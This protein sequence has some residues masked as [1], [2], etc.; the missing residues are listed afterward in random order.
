MRIGLVLPMFSGDPAK[1][2]GA[3]R[4]AEALGY[5]GVYAFDHFFP[6]GGSPDRPS[7][8]AFT[9][10]AAVAAV[11]ERVVIGTLVTRAS[12][13]PIGLLAKTA[14]W[15]D[16]ASDGRFVL[17]IG[18]GD[19]IDRPEHRAYGIPMLDKADRRI[20]LEE[21]LVALRTL[22]LGGAYPGGRWVPAIRGPLRPPASRPGGPPVWVGAQADEVVRLAG[23]LADGWNGWGIDPAS[24]GRKAEVLRQ[25]AGDRTVAATWAGIVLAGKDRSE[26]EHLIERRKLRGMGDD[27]WTGTADE[28]AV[29]LAD[30]QRAGA[31]WAVMVLAGPADR[32]RLVAERVLPQ[33][34]AADG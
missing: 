28:L 26:T 2:L 29:F 8:E 1:V 34:A 19:P 4:E 18:T 6:P 32:R 21:A 10:L 14:S 24:F 5:D 11:T 13:R 7:L 23:L 15:L 31:A 30:L 12:L 9:T 33:V 17:G 22:F 3:A 20:H 27:A 16:A 25:G